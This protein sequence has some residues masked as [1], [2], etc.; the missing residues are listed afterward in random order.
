VWAWNV[1]NYYVA[2]FLSWKGVEGIVLDRPGM[3]GG[4]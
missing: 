4:D 3:V 2:R 1:G